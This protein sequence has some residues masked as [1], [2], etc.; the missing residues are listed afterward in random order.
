M[1][2]KKYNLDKSFLKYRVKLR[3]NYAVMNSILIN[4]KVIQEVF[5]FGISTIKCKNG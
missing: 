4:I 3:N 5:L 1:K 2:N